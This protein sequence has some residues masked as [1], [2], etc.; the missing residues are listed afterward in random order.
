MR[1][2]HVFSLFNQFELFVN[3]D[4]GYGGYGILHSL[5]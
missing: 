5:K 4:L 3:Y 1:F 2:S